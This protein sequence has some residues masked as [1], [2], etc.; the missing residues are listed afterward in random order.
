[1]NKPIIFIICGKARTGKN[2]VAKI[3]TDYYKNS[4]TFS[5]TKYLKE[6]ALMISDW[7]GS[8]DRKP[9]E[10][11]QTLGTEI[12]KNKI[13]N[14]LLIRRTIEDIKVLSNFKDVIVI[15]GARRKDEIDDIKNTFN[16]VIAI[17][18]Y[19]NKISDKLTLNQ[20]KHITEID[21]DDYNNF[22]YEVC[23]DST[24]ESLQSKIYDILK[25]LDYEE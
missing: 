11:L 21:L 8:E 2:T 4:I 6:Y 12:I 20:N 15:S 14:K 3:I 23:N 9:R 17:K 7:D 13:D 18:V 22:D 5:Y 16:N 19:K 1:M 24:I 25:E 10:L